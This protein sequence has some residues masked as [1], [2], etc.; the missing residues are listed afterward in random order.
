MFK[1]FKNLEKK[2]RCF[3]LMALVFIVAQVWL[4]LKLPDYMSE[5]TVLVETPDSSMQDILIAGMV[6]KR[7]FPRFQRITL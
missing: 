7:G 3:I 1:L 5:I 2:D 6:K 4:D